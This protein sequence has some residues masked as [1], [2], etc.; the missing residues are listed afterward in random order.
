MQGQIIDKGIN[1]QGKHAW[2]I[3]VFVGRTSQGKKRYR[4]QTVYGGKRDADRAL[5]EMLDARD[6]GVGQSQF[7]DAPLRAY[8]EFW[9]QTAHQSSVRGSTLA[10]DV[11]M[12]DRHI[13]PVIGNIK[14]SKLTPLNIQS[15]YS[16]L[17]NKGLGASTVR[18]AHSVLTNLLNQAVDWNIIPN[19]PARRVRLPKRE[20]IEMLCLSHD[21]AKRLL[22]ACAYDRFGT[23]FE[24]MLATGVRP[25]EVRALKW[26]DIDLSSRR[27]QIRRTVTKVK[28]DGKY[29]HKL[30]PVKSKKSR[31]SIPLPTELVESLL[32]YRQQQI[33]R[34]NSGNT[35]PDDQL[36][37]CNDNYGILDDRDLINRHFKPLLELANLPRRLRLYDLRHTHATLLLKGG[38]NPKI[39]SER[40]GHASIAITLDTYSHV[41]PDMQQEATD[42]VGSLLYGED[43]SS[44]D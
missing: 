18:R 7:T 2:Q 41:L 22:D 17:Q 33:E 40:L 10:I 30:G 6:Q 19:N 3:K 32:Q 14:L 15:L 9:L 39:V 29:I 5:R 38:V 24:F 13:R 21:E 23:L 43:D 37:F 4:S 44:N 31:R 8:I 12:L 28:I 42:K 11:A 35:L 27:V 1:R 16:S 26:A 34:F 25:G 20:D 36:I